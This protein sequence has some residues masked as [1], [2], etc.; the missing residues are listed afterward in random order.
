M[1]KKERV[2][3]AIQ[4]KQIDRIPTIYRASGYL[5]ESVMNYF[6]I[7]EPK[8]PAERFK[9]LLEKVKADF[10]SSGSKVDKYSTFNP[11]FRGEKPKPPYVDDK[12][13]FYT[14]GIHAKP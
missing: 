5:I 6:Q 12:A 11:E 9:A 4:H 3:A 10:W 2:L 7:A 8:A 14:I 1:T 13:Y